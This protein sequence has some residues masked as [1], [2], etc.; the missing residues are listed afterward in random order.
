MN[1]KFMGIMI[2]NKC[3]AKCAMCGLSCSP[4]L[5]DVISEELMIEAI[6]Q[7]RAV[8]TFHQIGFT[9]G[10][11][12]LYPELLIKGTNYAKKFGFKVTVAGNGFWG[13]WKD[14]KIDSVLSSIATDVIFF[15]FDVFHN[16][17]VNHEAME[18]AIEGCR[19]NNK[20][21]TVSIGEMR[22]E[23]SASKFFKSMGDY[24]Y[25]MEYDIYPFYRVGRAINFPKENFY[26]L[27]PQKKRCYDERIMAIRYD[28]AVLPCCSPSI[29]DTCMILGNIKE[30]S[31]AEIMKSGHHIEAYE[32]IHD[33]ASFSELME[34]SEQKKLLT[35]EEKELSSCEICRLMFRDEESYEMLSSDIERLYDKFLVNNFFKRK[36]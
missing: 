5:N 15:S 12:F 28:G 18:R 34:I 23:Y 13:M 27:R 11:A 8:G 36:G 6:D 20:E 32:L 30:K 9:G 31:L 10:E 35:A 17:Y 7:A 4:E 29:V 1:K 21:F 22:G 3:N 16:E 33:A 2:T 14:E 24:K 26:P 19:R 25:M